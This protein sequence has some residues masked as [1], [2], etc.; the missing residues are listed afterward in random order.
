MRRYMPIDADDS[1]ITEM[2]YAS[3]QLVNPVHREL[4]LI[5]SLYDAPHTC[6][7]AFLYTLQQI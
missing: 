1:L 2:L 3:V 7:F 6:L 4:R 5:N